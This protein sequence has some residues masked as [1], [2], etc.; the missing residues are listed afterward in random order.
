VGL[1]R[2]LD[3]APDHHEEGEPLPGPAAKPANAP[4]AES[5]T[6]R[7]VHSLSSLATATPATDGERVYAPFGSTGIFCFD[8]D[9]TSQWSIPLP[10]AHIVPHGSGASLIVADGKVILNRD[11]VPDSYLLAADARSGKVVW[12]QKQ[13]LGEP[14][15]ALHRRWGRVTSLAD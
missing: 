15:W 6:D 11:E 5:G 7:E 9:G 4:L 3:N 14:E 10:V 8:V 2:L 1:R 13:Q 12:K